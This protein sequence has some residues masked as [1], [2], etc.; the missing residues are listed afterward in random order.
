MK[1]S[2]ALIT[3]AIFF[4]T[5]VMLSS[6]VAQPVVNIDAHRHGNLAAAQE[7]IVQ[8]YRRIDMA[9]HDNHGQLGGHAQHAKDALM[10]ADAQL[11]QAA[12]FA[13]QR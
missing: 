3:T 11:R 6:A 10:Q 13:N 12:T 1:R 2:I 9:Q 7:A 8:A 5:A 4:E